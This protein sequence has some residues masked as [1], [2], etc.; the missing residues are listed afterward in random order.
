MALSGVVITVASVD[1]TLRLG[2]AR[3]QPSRHYLRSGVRALIPKIVATQKSE[4]IKGSY[5]STVLLGVAHKMRA[6]IVLGATR[7]KRG[8]EGLSRRYQFARKA[9]FLP[10]DEIH[11]YEL[12]VM[13]LR[14][15]HVFQ[16]VLER[17]RPAFP[18]LG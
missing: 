7:S 6:F 11:V 12:I 13:A 8:S 15:A 17:T 5:E 2:H 9:P 4:S 18:S 16:Q 10:D 14:N 3:I 1:G